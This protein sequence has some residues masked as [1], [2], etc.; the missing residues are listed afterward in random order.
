MQRLNATDAAALKRRLSRSL[1]KLEP[2]RRAQGEYARARSQERQTRVRKAK[3]VRS[4]ELPKDKPPKRGDLRKAWA[5]DTTRLL[6][7]LELDCGC[8]LHGCGCLRAVGTRYQLPVLSLVVNWRLRLLIFFDVGEI[9][10]KKMKKPPVAK[11]L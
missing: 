11:S 10:V 9:T 7:V 2:L 5:M 4:S 3:L 1:S 6:G 8:E